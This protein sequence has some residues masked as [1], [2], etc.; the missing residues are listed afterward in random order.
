MG[1][2]NTYYPYWNSQVSHPTRANKLIML[3]EEYGWHLV[4]I[5]DTP[6]YLFRNSTGSS[7]LDLMITT[8]S[9]AREVSNW[10][11]DEENLTSS[12]HEVV[13]FQITSVYPDADFISPEP[14]LNWKKTN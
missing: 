5:P 3:I 4:N 13:I 6:T 10:A 14:H 2:L 1:N 8:L 7:V 9:V 11:V 12:D